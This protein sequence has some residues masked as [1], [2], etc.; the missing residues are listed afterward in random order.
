MAWRIQRVTRRIEEAMK[1]LLGGRVR[2][3]FAV[4]HYGANDIHPRH[5]VYW[6]CVQSDAE[7]ERLEADASLLRELRALL[8]EYAYPAEGRDQVHI[9]FES[10]QTVDRESGG[11][12]RHHFA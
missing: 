9:G 1:A 5:L 8:D 6:I 7:K 11:N 4:V 12:W 2:E 3:K 10:Q